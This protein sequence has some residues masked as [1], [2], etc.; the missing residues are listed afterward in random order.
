MSPR[1]DGQLEFR[2]FEA[3][4]I[5]LFEVKVY[6][7]KFGAAQPALEAFPVDMKG[8]RNLLTERAVAATLATAVR[9]RG[10]R[11]VA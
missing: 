9:L 11:E 1:W 3:A 7:Y 4:H 8:A 5:R 10:L 6:D 2:G